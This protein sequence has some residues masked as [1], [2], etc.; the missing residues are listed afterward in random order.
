ML[1]IK[2][3][4]IVNNKLIFFIIIGLIHCKTSNNQTKKTKQLLKN[5]EF[6]YLELKKNPNII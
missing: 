5:Q 1:A 2:K 4:N 3:Q 6:R